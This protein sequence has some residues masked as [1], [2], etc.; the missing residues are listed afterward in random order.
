MPTLSQFDGN[1]T[2]SHRNFQTTLRFGPLLR[3]E[4]LLLNLNLISALKETA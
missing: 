3:L 1:Y 2:C 4:F